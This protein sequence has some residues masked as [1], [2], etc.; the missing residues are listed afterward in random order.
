[1]QIRTKLFTATNAHVLMVTFL[2]GGT[3]ALMIGLQQSLHTVEQAI[4]PELNVAVFVQP[5]VTDQD[6]AQW[7]RTLQTTDPEIASVKFVSRDEALQKAQG[8]PALVKSLLLLRDN[9][10]PASVLLQYN[11]RAWL[12]RPEPALALR[13]MPQVQ[14]IRWDPEARSVFRSIRQWRAWLARLTI[15]ALLMLFIW[16]FFGIYRFLVLKA[17]FGQLLMQLGIGL[18]GGSLAVTTWGLALRGIGS[19]AALYRPEVVSFWPL[20][21]AVMAALATFGWQTTEN[22]E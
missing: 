8:N 9:P 14:E 16:C 1:M 15:F 7:A 6:A 21:A 2:L 13:S 20:V 10:F 4:R 22:H 12:E 3:G 11:D 5:N 19:D 18:I 17:S